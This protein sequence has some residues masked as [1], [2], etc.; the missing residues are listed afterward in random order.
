M[1]CTIVCRYRV[2]A[3]WGG[4]SGHHGVARAAEAEDLH[5]RAD[6]EREEEEARRRLELGRFRARDERRANRRMCLERRVRRVA[7]GN[8]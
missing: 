1:R 3:L 2:V 8:G 5:R 6:E 7:R 4:E